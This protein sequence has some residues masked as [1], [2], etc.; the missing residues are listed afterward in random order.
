MKSAPPPSVIGIDYWAWRRNQ[1]YGTLICDLEWR[2]TIALLP[3]RE[4]TTAEAWMARQPQIAVVAGDRGGAYALAARRA[5][6]HAVQVADRWHLM[7][8]ASQAFLNVVRRSMRQI[9]TTIGAATVN[10]APLTYA[11]DVAMH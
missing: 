10:P 4:P 5:L 2:E 9:R 11:E 3:D 8:S 6:P 7:K 1:R